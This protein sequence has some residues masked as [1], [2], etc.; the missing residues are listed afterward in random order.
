MRFVTCNWCGMKLA[1]K[2][3]HSHE[4]Y[5]SS[6]TT[7]CHLCGELVPR[8]Q[9]D[10]HLSLNHGVN[11]SLASGA[12]L[13]ETQRLI[14]SLPLDADGNDLNQALMNSKLA[15]GA[16][17]DEL[18]ELTGEMADLLTKQQERKLEEEEVDPMFD[19][20]A[21]MLQ[22]DEQKCHDFPCPFCQNMV[23]IS[24]DFGDHMV[25]CEEAM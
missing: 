12:K 11:P 25:A 1:A 10:I 14:D 22:E 20:S 8:N 24:E 13:I 4:V 17:D 2:D 5:C 6:Q 7:V 23:P 19:I 16:G 21:A 3:L 15:K 18:A 9:F